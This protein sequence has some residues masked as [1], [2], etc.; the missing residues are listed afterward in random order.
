MPFFAE[1]SAN[2]PTI[3]SE[4][5]TRFATSMLSTKYRKHAV[6]GEVLM[7]K[8]SGEIFIKRPSDEKIVSFFQNKQ[9]YYDLLMEL[10]MNLVNNSNVIKTP[11]NSNEYTGESFLYSV[12]FDL[13]NLYGENLINITEMTA[14]PLSPSP[15]FKIGAKSN[16]FFIRIATRDCDKAVVEHATRLKDTHYNYTETDIQ[17]R[18]N[19]SMMVTIKNENINRTINKLVYAKL[20]QTCAVILTDQEYATVTNNREDDTALTIEFTVSCTIKDFLNPDWLSD[21]SMFTQSE[22]VKSLTAPDGRVEIAETNIM[23]F[24]H[25][26]YD[27]FLIRDTNNRLVV[28]SYA[29]ILAMLYSDTL[30]EMLSITKKAVSGDSII[31]SDVKPETYVWVPNS[32]WAEKIRNVS[33]QGFSTNT[34]SITTFNAL[35]AYFSTE[36]ITG[37]VELGDS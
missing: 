6:P 36:I 17:Y 18:N 9:L 26:I 32:I 33:P 23:A 4:P 11:L 22:T 13:A 10:R 2:K 1:N 28:P 25:N 20:N 34:S 21:L 35:E 14:V 7:D 27:S 5:D 8:T 15:T 3:L 19:I 24:T 31:L 12:N 37:G 30:Y 29:H 16:G